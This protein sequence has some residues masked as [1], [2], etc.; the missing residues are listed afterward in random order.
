MSST[1]R[2][3]AEGLFLALLLVLWLFLFFPPA[4]RFRLRCRGRLDAVLELASGRGSSDAKLAA[5]LLRLFGRDS[6]AEVAD[7]LDPVLPGRGRLLPDRADD[8]ALVPASL[9]RD[10]RFRLAAG[11]VRSSSLRASPALLCSSWTTF[12]V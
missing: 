11:R 3:L 2:S 10:L 4:R 1:D 9:P 5:L 12:F 7:A 6:E 8:G